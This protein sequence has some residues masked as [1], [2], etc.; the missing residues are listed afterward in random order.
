MGYFMYLPTWGI[1]PRLRTEAYLKR[2]FVDMRQHGMTT[3]TLYPYGLP[4][5]R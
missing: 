4:S 2:I 3:A 5:A 1:P